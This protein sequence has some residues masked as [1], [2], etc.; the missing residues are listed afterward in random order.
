VYDELLMLFKKA[1]LSV[2]NNKWS[3]VFDFVIYSNDPNAKN[4]IKI[5]NN[6]NS[7]FVAP[8]AKV[9]E[10]LKK[11]SK[12]KGEELTSVSQVKGIDLS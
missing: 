7:N 2:F 9:K 3:E 8:F 11:A 4:Q 5:S 6:V 1:K 10:L 12:V